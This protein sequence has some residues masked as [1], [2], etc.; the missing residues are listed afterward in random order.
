MFQ[1]GCFRKDKL[2]AGKCNQQYL[3]DGL[4]LLLD[5][6]ISSD[7][8]EYIWQHL[9]APTKFC[10]VCIC[11]KNK[12][13]LDYCRSVVCDLAVTGRPVVLSHLVYPVM[14]GLWYVA[15]SI[16]YWALGGVDPAG[17]QYS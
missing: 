12:K 7:R 11:R 13:F 5:N 17:Q 2:V 6:L 10:L 3:L 14:F 15:F 9:S 4:H 1:N 16:A 8:Q